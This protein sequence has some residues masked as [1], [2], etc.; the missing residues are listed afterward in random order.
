MFLLGRLGGVS[1]KRIDQGIACSTGGL[2][3]LAEGERWV[4]GGC[5]FLLGRLGG[6]SYK[7][8][9]RGI[10][11][12]TSGLAPLSEGEVWIGGG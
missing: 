8:I 3:P 2:A 11:C 9:D 10:A 4:G 1:Y 7:R 12:S 6:V 5:L